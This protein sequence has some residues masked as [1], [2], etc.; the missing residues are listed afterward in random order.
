MCQIEANLDL[1]KEYIVQLAK[2]QNGLV[3]V[4]LVC[5]PCR[6]EIE[7]RSEFEKMVQVMELVNRRLKP[8]ERQTN[9]NVVVESIRNEYGIFSRIDSLV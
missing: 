8:L 9:I 3:F 7:T 6:Q 2:R 5:L 4:V 1:L